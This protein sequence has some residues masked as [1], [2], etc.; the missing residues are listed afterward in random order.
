MARGHLNFDR[1][2]EAWTDAQEHRIWEKIPRGNP[3]GSKE[4]MLRQLAVGDEKGAQK[5][6]K[7]QVLASKA[8]ALRRHGGNRRSEDF[9]GSHANLESGDMP[10]RG[11]NS[12]YLLALLQRDHPE[13]LARVIEGEFLS[14][15]AAAR[16][17]GI[18]LVQPNKTLTLGDDIGKLAARLKGH[19]SEDQIRELRERL[20]AAVDGVDHAEMA[21]NG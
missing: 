8:K 11:A 2:M 10:T 6:L 13:I 16:A 12:E 20:E 15:R 21:F 19:Y 3:Y 18:A 17:A 9:Q 4:E 5:R 1:Y 14:V 7:V